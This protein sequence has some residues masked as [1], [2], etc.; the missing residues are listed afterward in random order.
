M[1]S[2]A[3]ITTQPREQR[4]EWTREHATLRGWMQFGPFVSRV[5][6]QAWENLQR[7]CVRS[8]G[9]AEPDTAGARWWGYRF[10]Y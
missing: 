9:G 10:D 5:Q 1:P 8:D 7:D 2:R 6:A 4:L 3:G